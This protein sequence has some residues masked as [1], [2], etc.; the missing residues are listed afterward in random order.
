M[1]PYLLGAR[2]TT[3]I[4]TQRLLLLIPLAESRV[5]TDTFLVVRSLPTNLVSCKGKGSKVGRQRQGRLFGLHARRAF[6]DNI[7]P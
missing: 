1:P 5:D 7:T 2:V 4:G 3:A 6:H